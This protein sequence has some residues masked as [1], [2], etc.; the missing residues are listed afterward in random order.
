MAASG[1]EY[2]LMRGNLLSIRRLDPS[3]FE[4]LKQFPDGFAPNPNHSLVVVL[5]AD[6]KMVG[7]SSIVGVPHIEGTYLEPAYRKGA[8]LK[9]L[10]AAIE[11]EAQKEGISQLLSFAPNVEVESYLARLGYSKMAITVWEKRL[12][13]QH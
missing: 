10:I 9:K 7:R 13:C 3:E 1:V 4:L 8:L 11:V 2:F 12:P 6:E 5:S